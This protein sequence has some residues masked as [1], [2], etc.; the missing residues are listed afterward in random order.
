MNVIEN[1]KISD[2]IDDMNY[3]KYVVFKRSSSSHFKWNK[4][5]SPC[6]LAA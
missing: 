1:Y 4:K 5:E 6:H 2:D 3:S